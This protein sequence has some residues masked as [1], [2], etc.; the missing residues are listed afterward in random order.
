[1]E[2]IIMSK[3]KNETKPVENVETV[4]TTAIVNEINE[5]EPE[6]KQPEPKKPTIDLTI[7]VAQ[8]PD[9]VRPKNIAELFG[10]DDGGKTIRRTLRAKFADNHEAKN[11][12]VWN[13]TDK[14]LAAIITH[15][16]AIKNP[17]IKSKAQ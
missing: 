13:K 5:T 16:A 7:I 15:F 17:I 8:L 3:S 11:D 9:T 4:D 12:W 2:G 1:M 10:Y 6:T 14:T